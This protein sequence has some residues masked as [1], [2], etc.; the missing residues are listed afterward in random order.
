MNER[1][2][3][4]QTNRRTM[5]NTQTNPHAINGWVAV[6]KTGYIQHNDDDYTCTWPNELNDSGNDNDDGQSVF[7]IVVVAVVVN[8]ATFFS[9]FFFF[10]FHLFSFLFYTRFA[11][12]C[13]LSLRCVVVH[14]QN[15]RYTNNTKKKNN[16]RWKGVKIVKSSI[17]HSFTRAFYPNTAHIYSLLLMGRERKKPLTSSLFLLLQC[18]LQNRNALIFVVVAGI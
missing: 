17:A 13:F 18:F 1:T 5:W 8:A 2:R 10:V 9:I 16:K 3:K 7:Y 12:F 4:L 14:H 11:S 6:C 15:V